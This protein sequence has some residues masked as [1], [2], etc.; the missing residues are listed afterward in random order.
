MNGV[1]RFVKENGKHFVSEHHM[2]YM[3]VEL[4]LCSLFVGVDG[5]AVEV[6]EESIATGNTANVLPME[7]LQVSLDNLLV[8]PVELAELP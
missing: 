4:Q 1:M 2:V 6:M 8:L 7:L 5:L 3:L